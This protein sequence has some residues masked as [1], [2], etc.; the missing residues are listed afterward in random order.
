MLY[1]M[2]V[3]VPEVRPHPPPQHTTQ[4]SYTPR[5]PIKAGGENCLSNSIFCFGAV[6]PAWVIPQAA[7]G[8][9][10]SEP[11]CNQRK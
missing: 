1:V 11:S 8:K 2:A 7:A 6:D 4:R 9:P 3:T 10:P 5:P